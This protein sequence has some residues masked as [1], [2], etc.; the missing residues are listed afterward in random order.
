MLLLH[1]NIKNK[2]FFFIFSSPLIW[3][4]TKEVMLLREVLVT[5]P[6][7]FKEKTPK[8]GE[9]WLQIANNLNKS[10][11]FNNK[12]TVRSVREKTKS[13]VETFRQNQRAELAAT[14]INPEPTEKEVLLEEITLQI[15][16]FER[17]IAENGNKAK[18]AERDK[19]Q[20]EEIRQKAMETQGQTAKRKCDSPENEPRKT[21]PRSSG[22]DAVCYLREKH[23]A[24]VELREKE[25]EVQNRKLDLEA[26]RIQNDQTNFQNMILLMSN[27]MQQNQQ[28]TLAILER[29]TGG[30][31]GNSNN[32]ENG[33]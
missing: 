14:G 13:L 11:E 23:D 27:Q 16:E 19:L 9:K 33:Q 32:G 1:F 22:N 25:L 7:Q 12:A 24:D 17:Q 10:E 4:D 6:H 30:N 15:E 20:G 28:T 5:Q 26:N 31:R 21:K 3:T 8:R 2:L 18:D 29:L